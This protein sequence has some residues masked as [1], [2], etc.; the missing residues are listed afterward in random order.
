MAWRLIEQHESADGAARVGM[1]TDGSGHY[2]YVLSIWIAAA[3]EDEGALGDGL[4][5]DAE[6]SGL[7]G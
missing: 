5:M 6:V 2:R 1:Q 3:P 7:Y 4:W